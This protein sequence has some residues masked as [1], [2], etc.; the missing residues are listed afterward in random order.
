MGSKAAAIAA[1]AVLSLL[2]ACI[3]RGGSDVRITGARDA[4]EEVDA[5]ANPRGPVILVPEAELIE[6]TPSW[7][8]ATVERNAQLAGGNSY[9]VRAGDTLYKIG[10]E[11]GAGADA[12]ARANDLF[13]PF[14][15]KTGQS[16]TIPAG[17]YHRVSAGETGI[18][19]A[20]AYGVAWN[21]LVAL[22]MLSEPYVLRAGQFLRLPD[23]ASA[24][25]VNKPDSKAIADAFVLDIDAIVTG[26][27]PAKPALGQPAVSL[28]APVAL[29]GGFSGKFGWP[30]AGNI[31]GRFGAMGGG[32]VNDGIKIAASLGSN[33]AAAGDGVVV[34]SGNEIGV[35]GGLVMIDHGGGWI[36]AY[37]HLG[38]LA[39]K[40]G[41]K[42]TRGQLLGSVGETG[43]ATTPQLHFEMRKDRKPVDPLTKLPAR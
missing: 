36:T 31:V 38:T 6:T 13:P 27:Q 26:S 14:L 17:L 39:V 11:T 37:G 34:Y 35:L 19:I 42:V 7:N 12:I 33:V 29:P 1:F 5:T 4:P 16:L 20:R 43:L 40:R 21:E 25:P 41:A 24:L 10:N 18:A 23:A 2:S 32:R 15:L 9:T 22:N 30:L 3:P 28:G 8:P